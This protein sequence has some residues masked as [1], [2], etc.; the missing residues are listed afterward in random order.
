M[1][2]YTISDDIDDVIFAIT[3]TET[4]GKEQGVDKAIEIASVK[5]NVKKGFLEMPKSWFVKPDRPIHPSAMAIHHLTEED[6]KDAPPLEAVEQEVKDYVKGCVIIA[7]NAPFDQSM[8]PFL[9]SWPW[10]DS[11]RIARH[12]W[13]KGELNPDGHDLTSHTCQELRYWLG[14]Q[15]DT[16]GLPAHRAAADILVAGEVFGCALK[17]YLNTTQ[18]KSYKDFAEFSNAPV[19]MESFRLG[20]YRGKPFSEVDTEYYKWYLNKIA[21]GEM[22]ASEDEL[23]TINLTLNNRGVNMLDLVKID[24]SVNTKDWAAIA[25][26]KNDIKNKL[27]KK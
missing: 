22:S 24:S 18:N 4:T 14:L 20:K 15:I 16:M 25:N 9:D 13:K 5:W 8:L 1:N 27:F 11:L 10:L 6:I 7:H 19:I 12:I 26:A 23:H 3:D 21:C 17:K 2:D